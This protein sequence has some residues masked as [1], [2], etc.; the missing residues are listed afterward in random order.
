VAGPVSIPLVKGLMKGAAAAG[1]Y[2]FGSA[3]YLT[4]RDAAFLKRLKDKKEQEQ[5]ME[6]YA[7]PRRSASSSEKPE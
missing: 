2:A 4:G 3:A 7:Q 1:A 6:R 5:R